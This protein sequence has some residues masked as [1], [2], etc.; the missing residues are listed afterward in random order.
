MKLELHKYDLPELEIFTTEPGDYKFS[1]WVPDNYY[2]V[3][4]SSNKIEKSINQEAVLKDR[5]KVYKRP[6]GGETVILSPKT[7]VLSAL[8]RTEGFIDPQII[9]RNA[10]QLIMKK[11]SSIGIKGL[12]YR[13]ISDVAI[14]GKKILGSS[15][16]R[17]KQK[18][19]YH[20]VLNVHETTALMEKYILHPPREPGYRKGRS[21]KDFVTSLHDAGY[22]FTPAQLANLF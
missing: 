11:L 9:F 16:Y 2:L 8:V 5:I 13:G 14:D 3:L 18:A 7:V 20:A 12:Q 6:S 1:A 15:I 21:H 19:F 22:P 10:N 4:G 17:K